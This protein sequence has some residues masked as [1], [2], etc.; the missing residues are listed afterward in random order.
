MTPEEA[1][2]IVRDYGGA[3]ASLKEGDA[4]LSTSALPY[5]KPRIRYAFYMYIE[6]LVKINALDQSHVDA[7]VQTYAMLNTRFQDDADKINQLHKQ[8]AKD[9]K[10]REELAEYGGLTVGLPSIEEI[11]ELSAYIEECQRVDFS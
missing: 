4:V 7:L 11:Q 1:E 9:E 3:V 5:S 2:Q 10:A 8:Y 6:E